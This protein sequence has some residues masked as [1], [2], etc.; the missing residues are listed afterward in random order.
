MI[1]IFQWIH[2]VAGTTSYKSKVTLDCSS[3]DLSA[4]IRM[5]DVNRNSV[6][7]ASL[8]LSIVSLALL[9]GVTWHLQSSLNLLQEEVEYDRKL[10]SQ[11]Q[12]TVKIY[13]NITV[14]LHMYIY[15]HGFVLSSYLFAIAYKA[16]FQNI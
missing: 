15:T 7:G 4:S 9:F 11:D 1:K 12:D 5:T 14:L 8:I 13:L 3:T 2:F 16:I 6:L 10:E